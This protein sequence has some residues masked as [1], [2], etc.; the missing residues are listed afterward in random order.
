MP[1]LSLP[2]ADRETKA[3]LSS[4]FD[5]KGIPS[6]VLLDG[7]GQLITKDGRTILTSDPTGQGFPWTQAE[8]APEEGGAG[9]GDLFGYADK[10]R[11]LG[12]GAWRL[13]KS[14][15]TGVVAGAATLVSAPIVGA[16]EGGAK[17]FAAGLGMGLLGAVVLPAS[18]SLFFPSSHAPFLC[19]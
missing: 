18:F 7:V 5:I 9:F 11:H 12:E 13:F 16:R 4:K 14:V 17:G 1:W 8:V 15:G 3:K 10:P 19:A 6:L 2:F